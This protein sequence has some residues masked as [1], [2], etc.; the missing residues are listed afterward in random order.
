MSL[1]P[2]LTN[3][4]VKRSPNVGEIVTIFYD[5]LIDIPSK[6]YRFTDVKAK[7]LGNMSFSIE[8]VSCVKN[9]DKKEEEPEVVTRTWSKPIDFSEFPMDRWFEKKLKFVIVNGQ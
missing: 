1:F 3:W 4:Y 6:H 8:K 2:K 9:P 5:K 7:Y